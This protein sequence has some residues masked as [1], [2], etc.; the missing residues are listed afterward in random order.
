MPTVGCNSSHLSGPRV[1]ARPP[2]DC[3]CSVHTC[4]PRHTGEARSPS[5]CGRVQ[6]RKRGMRKGIEP[7]TVLTAGCVAGYTRTLLSHFTRR[8][9]GLATEPNRPVTLDLRPS[10]YLTHYPIFTPQ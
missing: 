1:S 4:E 3:K 9:T 5:I 8:G 2:P 7:L 6:L 10:H